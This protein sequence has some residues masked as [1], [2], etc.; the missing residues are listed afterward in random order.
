MEERLKPLSQDKENSWAIKK[1]G[2]CSEYRAMTK[3][4]DYT[5]FGFIHIKS[6]IWRGWHLIYHNKQWSTIYV[7]NGSKHTGQWFY[8]KEP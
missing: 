2:D 6:L 7:G 4:V 1:I 8:P 5:N 3:A